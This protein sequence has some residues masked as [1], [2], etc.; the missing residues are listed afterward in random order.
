MVRR[1]F[2]RC[3]A[4]RK[5]IVIPGLNH[6]DAVRLADPHDAIHQAAKHNFQSPAHVRPYILS[7]AMNVDP[8][9]PNQPSEWAGV[10][11]RDISLV[12]AAFSNSRRLAATR[13]KYPVN[14][15]AA[16]CASRRKMPRRQR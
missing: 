12:E 5:R 11:R 1:P 16:C 13:K 10:L 8:V 15:L 6:I 9:L 3:L 4:R 2:G 7:G 14:E